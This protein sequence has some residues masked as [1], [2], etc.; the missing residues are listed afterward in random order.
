MWDVSTFQCFP[1]TKHSSMPK[2][3]T[4]NAKNMHSILNNLSPDSFS[5]VYTAI[6]SLQLTL[7]KH[8]GRKILCQQKMQNAR[9]E[10]EAGLTPANYFAVCFL[11]V[12]AGLFLPVVCTS[13]LCSDWL[14]GRVRD[15]FKVH[16]PSGFVSHRH[17]N[18]NQQH[19]LCHPRL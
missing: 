2:S 6:L 3:L 19:I 8:N 13:V 10:A 14:P 18:G 4:S 7:D 15:P 16:H 12:I 17:W 9:Q 1:K 5:Q 11:Q